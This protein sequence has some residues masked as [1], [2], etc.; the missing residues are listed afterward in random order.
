MTDKNLTTL[1]FISE[2][3]TSLVAIGVLGLLEYIALRNNI[4]GKFFMPVVVLIS[5]LGGLKVGQL[6]KT[7]KQK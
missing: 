7:I 4:D 6:I 2:L 1:Q 5:G 3:L